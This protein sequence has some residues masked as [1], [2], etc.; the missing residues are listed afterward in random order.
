MKGTSKNDKA[1]RYFNAFSSLSHNL[2][3]LKQVPAG[4]DPK[5]FEAQVKCA[6]ELL[7]EPCG[8]SLDPRFRSP[9]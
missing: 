6:V 3:F 5:L 7:F 4:L 8:C 1:K 9:P 2:V